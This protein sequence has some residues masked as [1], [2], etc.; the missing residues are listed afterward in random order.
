MVVEEVGGAGS[1]PDGA[2]VVVVAGSPADPPAPAVDGGA[3]ATVVGD[4]RT[5][6]GAGLAV[7]DATRPFGDS[8]SGVVDAVVAGAVAGTEATGD[9]RPSDLGGSAATTSSVGS[10]LSV[11]TATTPTTNT[12]AVQTVRTCSNLA[13]TAAT[14]VPSPPAAASRASV[15]LVAENLPGPRRFAP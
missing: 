5:S 3:G 7:V 14:V 1:G 8:S 13:R 9:R 2:V 6:L 4:D 12:I 15:I 10:S 11:A